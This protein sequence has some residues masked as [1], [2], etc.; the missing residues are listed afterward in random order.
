MDVKSLRG[1]R[2]HR[3]RRPL[4]R[5]KPDLSQ[6]SLTPTRELSKKTPVPL[7]INPAGENLNA[8]DP[9]QLRPV[10][11]DKLARFDTACGQP[12]REGLL[13]IIALR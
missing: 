3:G 8:R 5:P 12:L 2:V 11:C 10:G 4:A 6:H 7:R 13:L 1:A 9:I